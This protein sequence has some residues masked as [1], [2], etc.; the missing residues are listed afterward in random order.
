MSAAE[1]KAERLSLA[2]DAFGRLVVT[3]PSGATV[4][5]VSPA[6][7]FP[8]SAP[9]EWISLLDPSGRE[10]VCLETLEGLSAESR[11]A[12][13][14]ALASQELM[15]I[16][17]RIAHV[18]R[19]PEPTVWQVLTDRGAREFTLTSDDHI[20]RLPPHGALIGDSHGVRYRVLDMRRL[21]AK[22]RKFLG[23]YL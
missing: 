18:T 1:V 3:L 6:R 7:C 16:I 17:E 21:D 11:G 8:F 4:A 20:R 12:L 5:G 14:R 23:R 9:E 10:L 22:S 13:Q 15:P 2:H 19:G